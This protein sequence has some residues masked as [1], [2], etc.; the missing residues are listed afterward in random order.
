MGRTGSKWKAQT[1]SLHLT[2][3][4]KKELSLQLK[5]ARFQLTRTGQSGALSEISHHLGGEGAAKT[6]KE[7]AA[8]LQPKK[9]NPAD[10]ADCK[11]HF[12]RDSRH[13]AISFISVCVA[14][15]S[16]RPEMSKIPKL[17]CR[18]IEQL[19]SLLAFRYHHMK[20]TCAALRFGFEPGVSF[21]MCCCILHK[22]FHMWPPSACG[23]PPFKDRSAF[24]KFLN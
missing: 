18:I 2:H 22:P 13:F 24:D 21:Q 19:F 12:G 14:L 6:A 4:H 11:G 23:Q 9:E 17:A 5:T 8:Q 20:N 7:R 15:S 3:L 1:P 16:Q 10:S